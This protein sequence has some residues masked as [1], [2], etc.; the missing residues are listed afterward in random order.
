MKPGKLYV[1]EGPDGC[2]KTTMAHKLEDRIG[3]IYFAFPGVQPGTLGKHVYELHHG[4]F[5]GVSIPQVSLQMLHVAAHIDAIENQIKP[6]LQSGKT[7]ALDRYY[8][9]TYIYGL[10]NGVDEKFLLNLIALEQSAW[11]DI[12]PDILFLMLRAEPIRPEG[13]LD[14]P[15]AYERWG[16]LRELYLNSL[17]YLTN[18]CAKR[19]IVNH[20][21]VDETFS[22]IMDHIEGRVRLLHVAR[23]PMWDND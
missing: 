13:K 22:D 17:S 8:W 10:H 18:G 6:A 20:G 16:Q 9:S 21:S 23:R 3:A 14:D 5:G 19:I 15:M 7:V 4:L 12:K 2:G 1:F 11:G